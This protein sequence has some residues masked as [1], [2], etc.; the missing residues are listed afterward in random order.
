M[1]RL[2]GPRRDNIRPIG[3]ASDVTAVCV[4]RWSARDGCLRSTVG[5]RVRCVS[6]VHVRSGHYLPR[7]ARITRLHSRRASAIHWLAG[8]VQS[9]SRGRR[10]CAGLAMCLGSGSACSMSFPSI[11]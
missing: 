9:C 2:Q 11:R 7:R 10:K 8:T 1:G 4:V 6:A 5:V 3:T